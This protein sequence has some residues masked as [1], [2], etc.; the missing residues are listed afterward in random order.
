MAAPKTDAVGGAVV[1]VVT[2]AAVPNNGAAAVGVDAAPNT[3][4]GA[5]ALVVPNKLGVAVDVTA[6]AAP[7]ILFDVVDGVI[8]AGAPNIEGAGADPNR[9]PPPTA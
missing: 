9:V 3:F 5:A 1:V 7:K 6:G 2:V 4:E 8:A